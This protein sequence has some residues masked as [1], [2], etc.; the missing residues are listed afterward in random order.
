MNSAPLNAL[1]NV[2]KKSTDP[3]D[4]KGVRHDCH[5]TL[6]YGSIRHGDAGALILRNAIELHFWLLWESGRWKSGALPNI[7]WNRFSTS[8]YSTFP[9]LSKCPFHADKAVI[10]TV[11]DAEQIGKRFTVDSSIVVFR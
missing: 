10:S 8:H 1:V 2:L 6:A 7:G 9:P 11:G 4:L 3:L 5:G